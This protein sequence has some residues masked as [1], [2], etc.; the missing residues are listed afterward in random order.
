MQW[1]HNILNLGIL[2][3]L[4]IFRSR[5]YLFLLSSFGALFN[6]HELI[7]LY[8]HVLL[9]GLRFGPFILRVLLV[10]LL[11]VQSIRELHDEE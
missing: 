1:R 4:P 7:L 5:F 11:N 8:L 2:D 10:E 9:E 3:L 6:C